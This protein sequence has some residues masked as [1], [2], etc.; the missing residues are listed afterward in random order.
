MKRKVVRFSIMRPPGHHPGRNGAALG[1]Y[2]RG[3]C[4]FN[5]IAIAVKCLD[6]PTLILD[7]DEHR[8]RYHSQLFQN[9]QLIFG[10]H[11]KKTLYGLRMQTSSQG[12]T[13]LKMMHAGE[14]LQET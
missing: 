14:S 11:Q 4:Y 10:Q 13:R 7:I 8:A 9:P 6:K 12:L 5:N 1:A 3:F 2:T